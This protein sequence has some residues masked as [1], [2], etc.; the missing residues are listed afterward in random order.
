MLGK[1]VI[2]MLAK[3]AKNYYPQAEKPEVFMERKFTSH[4]KRI[5]R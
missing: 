3:K 5:H 2:H 4:L 1:E